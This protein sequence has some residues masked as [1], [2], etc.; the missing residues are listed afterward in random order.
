MGF[1]AQAVPI[2][3]AC[4]NQTWVTQERLDLL[5]LKVRFQI[6][7]IYQPEITGEISLVKP[8]AEYVLD[9]FEV[10]LHF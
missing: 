4:R 5:Q 6:R 3:K 10:P 2:Y 1:D 8:Q 9:V 7:P